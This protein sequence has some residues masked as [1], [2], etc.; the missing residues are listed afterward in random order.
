M[1]FSLTC[2]PESDK[3]VRKMKEEYERSKKKF[4]GL[5]KKQEQLLRGRDG[6][7]CLFCLNV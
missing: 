2:L 5:V 6:K 1:K 4:D 7:Y 3:D